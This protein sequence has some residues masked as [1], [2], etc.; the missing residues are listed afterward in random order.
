MGSLWV[1]SRSCPA[2]I[3]KGDF[4]LYMVLD[5]PVPLKDRDLI[6][7]GKMMKETNGRDHHQE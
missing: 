4:T 6:V 1:A 2:M 5:F 7:Q 3:K